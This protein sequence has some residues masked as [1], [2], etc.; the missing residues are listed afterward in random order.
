MAKRKV[1]FV[2]TAEIEEQY[3]LPKHRVIRFMRRKL[4]PDPIAP[5][6]CG[7]VF[8]TEQVERAITRLRARGHLD[9]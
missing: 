2:G 5:L 9:S 7:L 8:R 1:E 6:K 4:F 3:G